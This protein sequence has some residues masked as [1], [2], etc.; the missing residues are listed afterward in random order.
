MQLGLYVCCNNLSILCSLQFCLVLFPL[1]VF[2]VPFDPPH[3]VVQCGSV[4]CNCH[5][6]VTA[7]PKRTG[8]GGTV[9]ITVS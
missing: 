2:Y 6:P 4:F 9:A 7:L 8:V 1:S 5:S 3:Y